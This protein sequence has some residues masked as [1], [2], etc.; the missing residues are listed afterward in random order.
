MGGGAVV[1]ISQPEKRIHNNQG[2]FVYRFRNPDLKL[3]QCTGGTSIHCQLVQV[4]SSRWPRTES[5]GSSGYRRLAYRHQ[6]EEKNHPAKYC[7][8]QL[9][10]SKC[11]I[12]G[13]CR[14]NSL[15]GYLVLVILLRDIN[16]II[17]NDCNL[18][19]L[20]LLRGKSFRLYP[21]VG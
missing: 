18:P 8:R 4:L 2:K 10:T 7:G 1:R 11:R 13:S 6:P 9:L 5:S 21:L 17:S 19:I 15:G 20:L 16:V 14:L 12:F 3:H